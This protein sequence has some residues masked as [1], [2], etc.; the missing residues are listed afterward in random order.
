MMPS[1]GTVLS[2]Q[3][4]KNCLSGKQEVLPP[5]ILGSILH[6]TVRAGF[7]CGFLFLSN[8]LLPPDLTE[9]CMISSSTSLARFIG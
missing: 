4:M 6:C 3:P 7:L 2:I 8:I 9:F 5:E 1:E